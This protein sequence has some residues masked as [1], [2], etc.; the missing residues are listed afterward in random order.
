MNIQEYIL[1]DANRKLYITENSLIKIEEKKPPKMYPHQDSNY[2]PSPSESN[3][4]PLH[5]HFSIKF[6]IIQIFVLKSDGGLA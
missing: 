5:Y 3:A 4:L 1:D 6:V 2:E